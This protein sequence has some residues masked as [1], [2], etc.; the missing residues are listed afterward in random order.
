LAKT[1]ASSRSC[2]NWS[3]LPT[4]VVRRRVRHRSSATHSRDGASASRKTWPWASHATT[5]RHHCCRPG[6]IG[7]TVARPT[8]ATCLL[9]RPST[10]VVVVVVACW[11]GGSYSLIWSAVRHV[12]HRRTLSPHNM[13][14][15]KV[16]TSNPT[17]IWTLPRPGR[18]RSSPAVVQAPRLAYTTP[19]V[20]TRS[21]HQ[22]AP[23]G[24]QWRRSSRPI[25]RCRQQHPRVAAGSCSVAPSVKV[26]WNQRRMEWRV[27]SRRRA[28]TRAVDA[29]TSPSLSARCA[30]MW[31]RASTAGRT[32]ARLARSDSSSSSSCEPSWGNLNATLA[33]PVFF[34]LPI[35]HLTTSSCSIFS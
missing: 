7:P 3:S 9:I 2:A 21:L 4:C 17:S 5:R 23:R 25:G 14:C 10:S 1:T 35:C 20:V 6:H 34:C 19:A 26:K 13:S 8:T 28:V 22:G 11:M 16:L 29:P 24:S 27:R 32:S 12:Y 33:S 30:E 31:L 18:S 15:H